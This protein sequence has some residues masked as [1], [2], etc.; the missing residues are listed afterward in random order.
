[1]KPSVS[2]NAFKQISC[3]TVKTEF[4]YCFDVL[5]YKCTRCLYTNRMPKLIKHLRP[6]AITGHGA[7]PTSTKGATLLEGEKSQ[8]STYNPEI[9]WDSKSI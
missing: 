2:R 5:F 9:S 6:K 7:T 8:L 1:M 4:R 3:F